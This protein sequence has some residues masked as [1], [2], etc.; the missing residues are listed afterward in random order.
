MDSNTAFVM[1]LYDNK[2]FILM[3]DPKY[4]KIS[5]IT[6]SYNQAEFLEETILSVLNQNY[7]NLEYII[8]DGGSNDGSVEIIRK[9]EK[10]LTYWISEPDNGQYDAINKGFSRSTGDIMA[11]INSDDKYLPKSFFIV[12]EM[13]SKFSEIKWLSTL[14]DVGWNYKG[15]PISVGI[16]GGY[17]KL[18]FYK[19]TYLDEPGSF[20][21]GWIQQESTFWRRDLWIQAGGKI[22][23]S[24]KYA[25]DFDLWARFF[26]YSH[27]YGIY[28]LLGGFRFQN[29][30]RSKLFIN[31]Y[32]QEAKNVLKRYNYRQY[33]SMKSFYLKILNIII[34]NRFLGNY[35]EPC[36]LI[37]RFLGFKPVKICQWNGTDW[38]ITENLVL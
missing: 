5:I 11:W 27:L 10:Y 36:K 22:D 9:Y 28:A 24:F 18:S 31:E 14:Y 38:E 30:Q 23:T 7:P 17:D 13:F 26:Q 35:P 29:M 25:G 6:P 21:N 34:A 32:I 33:S 37:L 20:T 15:H 16:R 3:F 2:K 8:I 12:A 19:G 4:P 1:I